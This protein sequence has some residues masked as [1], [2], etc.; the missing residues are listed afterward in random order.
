MTKERET[1]VRWPLTKECHSHQKLEDEQRQELET[2][3]RSNRGDSQN[4]GTFRI[5]KYSFWTQVP[6]N[7]NEK[8]FEQR[9]VKIFV[10]K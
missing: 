4:L 8:K 10:V 7:E 9:C 2:L 5:G 6:S 1:G 3:N